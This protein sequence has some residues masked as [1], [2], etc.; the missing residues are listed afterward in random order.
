MTESAAVRIPGEVC[1]P[2]IPMRNVLSLTVLALG[3]AAFGQTTLNAGELYVF[4]YQATDPDRFDVV[5][6]K[7][8]AAQTTFNYTDNGYS[9][10][11]NTFRAG[12]GGRTWTATSA[13]TAGTVLSFT[14]TTVSSG[15]IAP[16]PGLLNNIG[17]AAGGDQILLY[18]G[19]FGL[20]SNSFL[21]AINVSG[22]TAGFTNATSSNTSALPPGLVVGAS[23]LALPVGGSAI[24]TGI[25]TGLAT[26]L[27]SA[28]TNPANYTVASGVATFNSAPF[29]VTPVPEPASM[30]VL[31][32]GLAAL[33]RRR[34]G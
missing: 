24:Y 9:S 4:N 17:L 11:T 12:E 25:R 29:S 18:T 2:E 34:K 8:V 31:G 19:D 10:T 20:G 28:L 33:K 15:T 6:L 22:A 7:D 27:Q 14:S 16:T 5:I 1:R 32:L 26:D 3:A 23:A 30:A 13:I 21:N